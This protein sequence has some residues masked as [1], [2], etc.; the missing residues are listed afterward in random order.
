[1]ARSA[2]RVALA[3]LVLLVM[4]C[5]TVLG[6]IFFMKWAFSDYRPSSGLFKVI[7]VVILAA[8]ACCAGLSLWLKDKI[9]G[10]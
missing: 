5:A 3:Y 10:K 6:F 4:I 9:A 8:I 2:G 7:R 1:M